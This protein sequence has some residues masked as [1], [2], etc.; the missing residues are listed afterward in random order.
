[1][2]YIFIF[3][4]NLFFQNFLI[5]AQNKLIISGQTNSF[6]NGTLITISTF[7]PIN[8]FFTY[9]AIKDSAVINEGKFNLSILNSETELYKLTVK[10][11]IGKE[12]YS[13]LFLEPTS[14][15][16]FFKDSLLNDVSVT[17]NNAAED[18]FSFSAEIQ[19]VS[20]PDIYFTL[21]KRYDSIRNTN[22]D[23]AKE[24]LFSIDSVS[25]IINNSRTRVANKWMELHSKSAFNSYI[26]YNY[27][28]TNFKEGSLSGKFNHLTVEAKQNS[29]G[30][31]LE[32]IIKNVTVG[33][34]PPSFIQS[35]T[36]GRMVSLKSFTGKGKYILIDFWAS[37]C[38]PCRDQN[39][40]LR[41]IYNDFKDKNFQIIG[42][43]LDKSKEQWMDA[44][45]KDS[46][47]WINISDLKYWKNEI[48]KAYYIRSIPSQF[49]LDPDGRIIARDFSLKEL[50]VLLND[51]F[52]NQNEKL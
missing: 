49:L 13:T 3:L 30:K 16:I 35:D 27:L 33:A 20:Y 36:S 43:S 25:V 50:R 28:S 11:P 7:Y 41:K 17:H 38:G 44:I 21:F 5:V 47:P 18:Y 2:K 32:Y 12:I 29:W 23:L 15:K 4:I 52:I 6:P 51:L 10:K 8:T 40:L 31:E 48:A 42:I 14:T 26:I 46:L 9:P 39:P 19:K 22:P 1:M 45:E 34:K 37:W 24:I